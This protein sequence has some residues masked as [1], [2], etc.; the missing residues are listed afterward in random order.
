MNWEREE[1]GGGLKFVGEKKANS[2]IRE[3]L[4]VLSAAHSL[5]RQAVASFLFICRAQGIWEGGEAR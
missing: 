1:E 4:V 5:Y 2:E 3:N